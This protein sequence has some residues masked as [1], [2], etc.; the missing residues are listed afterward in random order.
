MSLSQLQRFNDQVYT[1]VTEMVDQNV[2]LFNDASNGGLILKSGANPGDYSDE[3]LWAK[4]ANMVIRRDVYASGTVPSASLAHLLKTSVKVAAGTPEIS[5]DQAAL[6]WINRDP[7]EYALVISEQLAEDILADMLNVAISSCVAATGAVTEC[8][9]DAT[10]GTADLST[11]NSGAALFGDASSKINV[12]CMHSKV[13][14][15]IWGAAIAN[16]NQLFSYGTV[17]VLQDAFGRPLIMSDSPALVTA[18]A[19]DTYHTIGLVQGGVIVEDNGD[20]N[21]ETPVATGN[22]NIKRTFQAEWS[23]NLGIKGYAWDKAAG[24]A[25]PSDAALATATNWD[26][27]ATSHK[28]LAGVLINSQ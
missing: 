27:Y 17:Q 7:D 19:P 18:G 14:H 22:T 8:V 1:M 2:R 4:V 24:G 5:I 21:S 11:L 28:D 12:W 15:D 25:S 10:A 16:A 3:A 20:F 13:M 23:Y 9:Y 6:D 26:R